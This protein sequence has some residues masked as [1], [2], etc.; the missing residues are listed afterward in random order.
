MTVDPGPF[1]TMT[2]P[3]PPQQVPPAAKSNGCWK[4][5]LIGCAI[6]LVLGA[7]GVAALVFGIFGVIKRSDVYTEARNRA[8]ADPRVIAALGQPI[9][10]GWL[11]S[12]SVSV[13]DR[14]GN[15]NL[16]FQISGPKGDGHVEAVAS[17]DLERWTFS[18][19]TV[20]PSS[21]TTIDI[22]R[23]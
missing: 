13:K 5:G 21:G 15:A 8:V 11:V 1:Q 12:G 22:L 7:I 3:P 10:A 9:K 2:P 4:F 23:P 16:G 19:L 18:T 20:K 17:R 6:V 14:S